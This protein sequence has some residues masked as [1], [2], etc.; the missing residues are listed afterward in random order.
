[1][2]RDMKRADV[3]A[4]ALLERREPSAWPQSMIQAEL[5]QQHGHALV[6]CLDKQLTGWCCARSVDAEAE[7]LKIGV[8]VGHRRLAIGTALLT[9][10]EGRLLES[11]VRC[12]FLEVR[13][14]NDAAL[15]FYQRRGFTLMD[16][17][18]NYFNQ[19]R[20]DGLVLRKILC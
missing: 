13:S 5:N 7:L 12:I 6:A 8:E 3:E 18:I 17:R 14:K 11:G 9:A 16:R 4:V 15:A 19:P 1:M 10:L 20:D 2:L